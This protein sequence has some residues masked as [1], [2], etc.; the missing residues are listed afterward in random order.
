MANQI[1]IEEGLLDK[2]QFFQ[3][4]ATV[5]PDILWRDAGKQ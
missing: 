3:A 4:D 1:A 5:D 2:V